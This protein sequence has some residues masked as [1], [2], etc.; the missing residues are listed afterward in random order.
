MQIEFDR[1]P[2][3]LADDVRSV[4]SKIILPDNAVLG[5]LIDV[6]SKE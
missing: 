3:C 4:E 5:E 2:V 6:L 1:R